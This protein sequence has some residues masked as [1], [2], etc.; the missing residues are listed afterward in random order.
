MINYLYEML[1]ALGL[2][3]FLKNLSDSFTCPARKNFDRVTIRDQCKDL[4]LTDETL[5]EIMSRLRSAIETGLSKDHHDSAIVKCFITYIQDLPN[6]KEKGKFLALDLGGTNFRVLIIHL[7]ENH[8]DMQ[9]KIYAI[10][11]KIMVGTGEQLFDHIA[12]C[13]ADFMK[14]QDV[15][16]EK[17]PLGFTFSF[18][19]RQVG[20]TKGLLE[21]WTKGFNCSGVVGL[22]VVQLL[23]DA[24][25]RRN[26]VQIEVC[27]ILN[28]TTGTLMSCAWKNPNC[29]IGIIVGTGSNAC[30]VEKVENAELFDGDKS[31]PYVIINTEWGAFG[32]DGALDLILTEYD[33]TIDSESINP[34]KQLFEKMISGM[35][36]GELA[37]LA[38]V[39][40]T[41][42]KHMFH[43][44]GSEQLF[45]K[46]SFLTK[47]VSEIESDPPGSFDNCR[48]ILEKLGLG[49]A[50]EQDCINVRYICECVSR[51]A[52]HLV[53][54][55]AATLINKME[56]N[57]VTVGV[58]GSVYRFH[59]H[60]H[61]LMIEKIAALIDTSK[62][63]F[64][65]MLSEDGSGRGAALVAA[66]ACRE[67]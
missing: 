67:R 48:Q 51:R 60:F 15:H 25:A 57:S 63:K 26:D 38:L 58:D 46:G 50:T 41:K 9:S 28:D 2:P 37:R 59:P 36:M 22:D 7:D 18:P 5:Q 53:S 6:G 55:G 45:T 13:L 54:A 61:S 62:Y 35:Y 29:K 27:A 42:E 49:H 3:N 31:K 10:P 12:Q 33:R 39:K 4:I 64:D 56:V 24:L 14:E 40:F 65:L 66:V 16:T 20:L 21:R 52:A 19:L 11:E 8:F 30:Y 44:Q 1:V 34:G 17:L 43:G 47:Y 23:K 32:D